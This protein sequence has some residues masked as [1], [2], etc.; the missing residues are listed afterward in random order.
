MLINHTLLKTAGQLAEHI[1]SGPNNLDR[2]I[3]EHMN[4][5]R[6]Y[7]NDWISEHIIN[8]N[9]STVTLFEANHV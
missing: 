9:T 6:M 7:V 2:W 5:A 1:S 3:S 4:K 8:W